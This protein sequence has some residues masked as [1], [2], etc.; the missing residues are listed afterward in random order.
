MH[1]TYCYRIVLCIFLGAS[2]IIR[3]I[4][5]TRV[6][7][8]GQSDGHGLDMQLQ[9]IKA[10]AKERGWSVSRIFSDVHTG[11]GKSSIK[12]R[13]GLQAAIA[14]AKKTGRAILISG[15]DR[16]S[17][18]ANTFSD[19]IDDQ[20]LVIIDTMNGEK[21]DKAILR[22]Q[23]V[24]AESVGRVISTTT[25]KAL[26]SLKASGKRL[27]N[28]TNFAEAQRLGAAGNHDRFEIASKEYAP[29]IARINPE[30]KL[31]KKEIADALN[32]LGRRTHRGKLWT[33]G[34]IRRLLDYI[35]KVRKIDREQN[36]PLFGMFA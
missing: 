7:T 30:E 35:K 14:F 20:N 32:K 16:I 2:I 10:F 15:V 6:S 17:R 9:Q 4:A 27:G 3:V 21:A 25:K 5:Y 26:K 29:I 23:A 31:T 22:A 33:A 19:L 28:L 1:K 12:D 11:M 36:D 13:H 34:N 8:D 18:D 24:K